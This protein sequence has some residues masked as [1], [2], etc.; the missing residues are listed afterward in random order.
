MKLELKGFE[1]LY[2]KNELGRICA[3][4]AK[5]H[6]NIV[7]GDGLGND[8]LG[9]V[10]LPQSLSKGLI[11]DLE[12][13]A[14]RVKSQSEVYVV[15]GIGGSYLG[16]KAIIEALQNSFNTMKR[17]RVYPLVLFAGHNLSEDYMAD[18]IEVLDKKNY[19][20]VVISKSGTTLESAIG[21]RILRNHLENKYGKEKAR[22]RII[23]I[24]DANKGALKE[25]ATKEG[26]K[27]YV[28]PDDIGGRFSVLSPV[29]LLPVCVAG[30]DIRALIQGAKRMR[31]NLMNEACFEN[32]PAWQYAAM[33]YLMH[34]KGKG[35]EF[36]VSYLPNLYW[37]MEWF[38][39][40]FGESEGKQG[41]GL[42]PCSMTNTTDLHSLGQYAQDG[43][44]QFFETVLH[45]KKSSKRVRIPYS[46]EDRDGLNY[47][48]DMSLTEINHRAQEATM[49]A[50]LASDVPQVRISIDSLDEYNLGQLIYF[51]EFSCAL[52]AYMLGVNPF[53]QPGV[54]HYK[55]NMY[56]LLGR[57]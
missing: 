16:A 39:Q 29:G 37:F 40:L 30:F 41:K 21:F 17:E 56:E 31:H 35:V 13:E 27:T 49:M 8:F 22:E 33:R 1:G 51:F 46:E 25:M 7:K 28:I 52:S 5:C 6:L 38:K 34:S 18:L 11:L 45:V 24:T 26:Y 15:I 44:R 10:N 47:L 19:S 9:W 57:K 3:D 14:F 23:A 48:S 50:H 36:M 4:L 32:N 12:A 42:L 53:D 43:K 54:E 20:L 2:T 55:R